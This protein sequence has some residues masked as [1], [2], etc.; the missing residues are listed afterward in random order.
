[1]G[2][3]HI[4]GAGI[5]GLAAAVR[6]VKIGRRVEIYEAAS[7]AGGRCRSFFDETVGRVID[8]GNH[9]LLSGNRAAM[10]YLTEIG[11]I[12]TLLVPPRAAFPFVELPTGRRW[13]VRP[14]AGPIPWWILNPAARVPDTTPGDYLAAWR[15][16]RAGPE[17]RVADCFDTDRPLFK[18]FWQPLAVAVLNATAEEAAA[19]P[20][21][22]IIAE[23]FAKGEA[24]CRPCIAR[25]GLSQS[26]VDPAVR[27]LEAAGAGIHFN[28][29]LRAISLSSGRARSLDFGETRVA[30]GADDHA[31]LALPPARVAEL[32]PGTT[33]PEDTRAIVNAHFR[34][35]G[36]TRPPDEVPF[37]GL[38][39][40][41][42]Q[43]LF[44]RGNVVSVTVSAADA[45]AEEAPEKIATML[46]ADISQALELPLKPEPL[47]R[48]VKEK[49]ATFAQT[50]EGIARRP[51]TRTAWANL[52][53]AGDWTDT[54]LPATIEGAVRSG[55]A[56]ARVIA[57]R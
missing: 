57:G 55:H 17:A 7:H 32:L 13:V 24:A 53:L 30:L 50:P 10:A 54:G 11:S 25:T 48:I 5:A 44:V 51:G 41:V 33:V 43:W 1:M 49:R 39:G 23:T 26:F 34:L 2:I 47:A 37:L 9:L 42:A 18:R 36:P 52:L 40:S 56:A 3:V 38:V 45:L 27:F 46:W 19:R 6:L 29:R 14:N 20:L 12:D 35:D 4:L 28:H 22:L 8:N 16:A 21:W 31:V 15:L